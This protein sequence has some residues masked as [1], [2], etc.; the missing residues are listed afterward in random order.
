MYRP[1]SGIAEEFIDDQ[2]IKDTLA[3]AD[4]NKN[5]KE[6][7]LSII[8][9]AKKLKGISHREASVLLACEDKELIQKVFDLAIK[10]KEEFY[11]NRIVMFAPLYLANYCVNGCTYCPY[12][13]KNKHIRRKKLT[14]EEI[15]K[16]VIALQD[17]GHKRLALETGEDPVNIPIEYVLESIKTIY[18]IKHKNG[19]IRRVNVN[20]AAT[21]VEN[22]K[23]LKDVGIGTYILFQETYHKENYEKLHP[24]GPK[25]DYAYH[26]EA[27]DRA[28]DGGIDDVG[29]GVLFGL[30]N[31][32]YDFAGII[33]HAEHLEAAK[34]VGP[35][36]ISVPRLRRAD[37]IDPDV[38]DNGISDD[39][40]A[41]IVA[42]I[43]I[44][45]PYT[46][47]IVSTRESAETR[48][49]VL[50]LGISQIS[51][52]SRTS[53]G[54]YV[55][56]EPEEERPM[57]LL[58]HLGE[59][60][61]RLVR[62]FL[63]ILIGFFACYG[64]AQQLFYYLSLPLLKVMPA[65]SKFI[66]TGVAEGFFVDMKVAFVAGVFVAC[67]FL[68]YQ[69]WAFIAPGLYEEEKKYII[70]LALSSALFF[71]L[72][73][74]FCYFGVFPFAFEFFMSYS[75]D[76]IVAMLSI[77]EYLSFALK[78]VL[79][80][81]LIFEMPL[82]SF[83]LARMGLITAQKMREV[84]KYAILAIFV[85]AAILTPPDVVS[86]LLMACPMLILYEISIGVAALFGRD[87][88]KKDKAENPDAAAA[89]DTPKDDQPKP[90]EGPAAADKPAAGPTEDA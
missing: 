37:D 60:R 40:F 53:V 42:C 6:L 19:A 83:F 34:G 45:V 59:L 4:A 82:F 70:P 13:Y 16:E 46:G 26:T 71:I 78:M 51:G 80:F 50:Q 86:Q 12:H 48:K 23:K 1:E 21:T 30:N 64:F 15:K 89:K 2:E 43:R 85:V 57:T 69:I 32:R 41:K 17:M 28:M 66:Y 61:K 9:K 24:T 58:E 35:H 73:G 7:I 33:M 65:D 55:E 11:G 79:A 47:M 27:M 56:E 25:H 63:A 18:S 10:I 54:G 81:G 88:N 76:N 90:E 5:N 36:T 39:L 3:Y 22:Y 68:F 31:Y 29:L 87:R 20:I 74:V 84:R 14:Q 38:F 49:K 52:G 44:A 72:G 75:T 67:P 62:G 77:D 8:E